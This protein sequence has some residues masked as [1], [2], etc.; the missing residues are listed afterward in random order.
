MEFKPCLDGASHH[1]LAL[2]LPFF[3]S[4]SFHHNWLQTHTVAFWVCVLCSLLFECIL[5]LEE[6]ASFIFRVDVTTVGHLTGYVVWLPQL[7]LMSCWGPPLHLKMEAAAQPTHEFSHLQLA[8][9]A[10]I[11][12]VWACEESLGHEERTRLWEE[13]TKWQWDVFQKAFTVRFPYR[14]ESQER[15]PRLVYMCV[16]DKWRYGG[17]YM[18]MAWGKGLALV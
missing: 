6:H 12:M 8:I 17:G 3:L 14:W 13:M 18:A 1:H 2:Q 4:P 11:R 9:E 15:G 5:D 7:K 10:Q 16:P